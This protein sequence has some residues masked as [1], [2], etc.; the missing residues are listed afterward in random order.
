MRENKEILLP[1][2]LRRLVEN[3]PFQRDEVGRSGSEVR[4]Y[5]DCV[6][7]IRPQS[8]EAENEHRML[9]WLEGRLP[10]PRCL[11][12]G[13]EAGKDFLLMS[14][15]NGTMA[16]DE[17]CME[18]ENG[19]F[20]V[21]LMAEALKRL[22]Q[23]DISGCPAD[24]R[25]SKAL[26]EAERRIRTGEASV[27][28]ASPGIYGPDGFADPDALLCWL[29]E[30]Q[31]E[32]DLVFSHGDYCMPN[33]LFQ[34]EKLS[35]YIDLGNGG[36][37]DRWEDIAMAHRSLRNNFCGVFGGKAYKDFDPDLL[38]EMLGME[39][40]EKKFRYYNLLHELY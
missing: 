27:D 29:R 33:V 18:R 28:T 1:E 6:L 25:L 24:Q 34:G 5:E 21:R 39:K 17:A 16:C 12:H 11:Y 37:A 22:W 26:A 2:E 19:R 31:P 35:G 32:E 23:V 14:R 36:V 20:A 3:K 4:L 38:F 8:D 15:I 40:D 7:K 13:T 30:N 9:R 10:A